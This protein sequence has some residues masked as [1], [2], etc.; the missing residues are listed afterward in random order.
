VFHIFCAF[1]IS[2]VVIT[3]VYIV[4]AVRLYSLSGGRVS[5]RALSSTQYAR[6]GVKRM[7]PIE[8]SVNL[9][10]STAGRTSH[11]LAMAALTPTSPNAHRSMSASVLH[12]NRAFAFACLIVAAEQ[13][14]ALLL[15]NSAVGHDSSSFEDVRLVDGPTITHEVTI[16]CNGCL[17]DSDEEL[18]GGRRQQR[19]RHEQIPNRRATSSSSSS[20]I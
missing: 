14:G 4:M 6:T 8:M 1:W 15:A 5:K 12:E 16:Q 19:D 17:I 18:P 13:G 10:T 9:E 11:P 3:V 7:A 2:A 20:A